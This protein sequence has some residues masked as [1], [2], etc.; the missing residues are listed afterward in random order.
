M[1]QASEILSTQPNDRRARLLY[2]SGL[3]GTGDAE[4]ARGV[5]TRLIKDFPQDAEPQVQMGLLALSEKE[6]HP[7]HRHFE[8]ASRRRAMRAYLPRWPTR[9]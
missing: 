9:I 2:A 8:Q 7:G 5:L 1:Q 6:F 3:I 4:A